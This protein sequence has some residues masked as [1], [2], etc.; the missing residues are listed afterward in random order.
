[1]NRYL[2]VM[3]CV[4]TG[5]SST[6]QMDL[7][8]GMHSDAQKFYQWYAEYTKVAKNNEAIAD[9]VKRDLPKI[10]ISVSKTHDW[11]SLLDQLPELPSVGLEKQILISFSLPQEKPL[12]DYLFENIINSKLKGICPIRAP[13][14]L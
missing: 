13:S 6:V 4:L 7:V 9:F 14:T 2:L 10:F 12:S 8:E 11:S 5:C 3:F 1:M